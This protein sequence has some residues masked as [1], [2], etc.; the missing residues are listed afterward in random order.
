MSDRSRSQ[1]RDEWVAPSTFAHAHVLAACDA[2]HTQAAVPPSPLQILPRAPASLEVERQGAPP[3]QALPQQEPRRRAAAPPRQQ[4]EGRRPPPQPQPCPAGDQGR[5]GGC[6]GS[7]SRGA[8]GRGPEA[9]SSRSPPPSPPLRTLVCRGLA[10]SHPLSTSCPAPAP[11]P[12]SRLAEL[13]AAMVEE[14]V[15]LRVAA[16]VE[17][18]VAEVLASAE[19]QG[20]LKAR[21]A[22]QRRLLAAEVEAE[23]A[24]DARRAEEEAGRARAA[25]EAQRAELQQLE[26]RRRQQASV[27]WGARAG[28]ERD[29]S[30]FQSHESCD[31]SFS[32]ISVPSAGGGGACAGWG[33]G[34]RGGG[35]TLPGAAAQDAGGGGQVWNN[36]TSSPCAWVPLQR[37]LISGPAAECA[38]GRRR[39]SAR[40]S[41]GRRRRRGAAKNQNS[42][43]SSASRTGVLVSAPFC[44]YAPPKCKLTDPAICQSVS[45]QV[46]VRTVDGRPWKWRFR[47]RRS[48][49]GA[50]RYP[51]SSSASRRCTGVGRR[52]AGRTKIGPGAIGEGVQRLPPR[53]RPPHNTPC[54]PPVCGAPRPSIPPSPTRCC[55]LHVAPPQSPQVP[56]P[57]ESRLPRCARFGPGPGSAG[58]RPPASGWQSRAWLPRAQPP[59]AAAPP[60]LPLGAAPAERSSG[61]Q[62]GPPGF[63]VRGATSA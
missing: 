13:E 36:T 7:Q 9:V 63:C 56:R 55:R 6:Y 17:A 27:A 41:S 31:L 19:V 59:G 12:R 53:I 22:E 28:F 54:V 30:G 32:D 21:L 8:A 20:T 50:S 60:M 45:P 39:R 5:G 43:S 62:R 14:E 40:S 47:A 1:D 11:F 61:C 34:G 29:L 35:A 42:P 44:L 51:S 10:C 3:P 48:A 57:A 38:G 58:H 52:K 26:A 49:Q 4:G 46:V 37:L 25:I 24:E 16:A 23:L 33:G 15:A 18:R 2:T